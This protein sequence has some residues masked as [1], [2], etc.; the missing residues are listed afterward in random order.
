MAHA[1]RG[2]L[3]TRMRFSPLPARHA[4]RLNARRAARAGAHDLSPEAPHQEGVLPSAQRR[5]LLAALT[6]GLLGAPLLD[7]I[8]PEAANAKEA[9]TLAERRASIRKAAA[10]AV[11]PEGAN[12]T[13]GS[14]GK[15]KPAPSKGPSPSGGGG[16]GAA[17]GPP[18]AAG[19]VGAAVLAGGAALAAKGGKGKDAVPVKVRVRPRVLAAACV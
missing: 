13:A 10:S 8:D 12:P 15:G 4:R 19:A 18:V 5:N 1:T 6:F 3:D 9:M 14:S 11:S 16:S 7:W 17:G 2:L